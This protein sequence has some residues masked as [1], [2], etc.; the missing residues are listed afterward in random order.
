M[1]VPTTDSVTLDGRSLTPA[2]VS[3]VA[4]EGMAVR[5][6]EEARAR[7]T[8]AA[9]ATATLLQRGTRIYGLTTGVG[10]LR[11]RD[12]PPSERADHQLRLLRSHAAGAGRPL[13]PP[14]VRA[15]M[16]VRAN[17]LGAGG[18]GVSDELLG[19][20]VGALNSGVVPF[21]R[22]LG[23]LG[24]GDLTVLAEIALALIGEGRVWRGAELLAAEEALAEAGLAAAH[25]GPRDGIAFMSSSAAS[26]G[27]A[28]LLAVDADRLLTTSLAVSALSFIAAGADPVVFD[29]RVH[30]AR[31]HPGQVAV[32]A[33]MR[34]LLG[35]EAAAAGRNASRAPVHDPYPF[36]ALAQVEGPTLDALSDLESVL[37]VE[38]NAA[39]ENALIDARSLEVLPNANFHAAPIALGLDRLRTAL[40]QSSSLVA[41]RVSALLDPGVGA[42]PTVLSARPG[43]ES[44]AMMLEYT[45]HAAAADVL[46]LAAPVATH[47]T[48]VGGG[49]ESHASFAP[50]AA[51]RAQQALDSA[52]VAVAV[53]LVVAVR[54]LRMRGLAP[55]GTGAG[56]LFEAATH[57]LDADLRDRALG[58]DVEAA[59]TL[60]FDERAAAARWRP[61]SE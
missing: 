29:A 39:T 4:R 43:P 3:A 53:E 19:A 10:V 59:R 23:S 34:E 57:R 45:A 6:G 49:I 37:A 13:S 11:S 2:E 55:A 27:H 17:Q 31:P 24:T 40:A 9:E 58:D 61:Q 56:D 25:L 44:G 60:L 38:L 41:V 7:N 33:R 54:A 22:E 36:R 14:L 35:A 1:A 8:A 5:L 47:P 28:A 15:A 50:L 46:S 26:A 32:A 12:V 51:R 21:A 18:A 52:A 16:A 20:L 42:L 30:A 48:T